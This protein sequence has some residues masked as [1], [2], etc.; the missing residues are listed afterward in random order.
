MDWVM[1]AGH[2]TSRASG[3]VGEK[4]GFVRSGRPLSD[5]RPHGGLDEGQP[6]RARGGAHGANG[7]L[8][9]GN[10]PSRRLL[11]R[12]V[13]GPGKNNGANIVTHVIKT[14]I[15]ALLTGFVLTTTSP[16]TAQTPAAEA[17]N[18]YDLIAAELGTGG[19]LTS[20]EVARR[21][22][23]TSP[24]T[25]A[26]NEELIAA[27]ARVDEAAFGYIP[28]VSVGGGYTRL[29]DTGSSN[30]GNIV[31]APGAPAGPITP[32]T[33]L[34]NVP[35]AFDTPLNQN[36]FQASIAVPTHARE[37]Q[38]RRNGGQGTTPRRKAPGRRRRSH[39]LLRLG[40]GA[41]ERH[42]R[43][44]SARSS[45]GAPRGRQ[46]GACGWNAFAGGRPAHRVGSRAK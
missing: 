35:L 43:R 13:N 42:R 18:F 3:K 17:A 31:A 8:R 7:A 12:R 11:A 4:P 21:A 23:R 15:V 34:V 20:N 19:G 33:T 39:Q 37:R 30:A 24:S 5:S 38:V 44:A 22:S 36:T 28:R 26:R 10:S 9:E 6:G 25:R 1:A 45:A 40:S 14:S 16:A 27:A 2:C 41:A 29:S 46:Q 32:G